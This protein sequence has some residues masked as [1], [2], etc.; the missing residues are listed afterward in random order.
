M[1][2]QSA[3]HETANCGRYDMLHYYLSECGGDPNLRDSRY[4]Q[5]IKYL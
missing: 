5:L 3:L 1:D 4:P 2:Q